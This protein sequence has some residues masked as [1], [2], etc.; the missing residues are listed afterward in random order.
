MARK[1][2]DPDPS[3]GPAVTPVHIG[4]DSILDRLLPNKDG[5]GYRL[6]SSGRRMTIIFEL[7]QTRTTFLDMFE[8]AIPM[9][10][11]VGI[12]A[13]IRPMDRSLWETRVRNGREFSGSAAR[14]ARH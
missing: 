1:D 5:E 9:F 2:A 4:G 12:D 7:D 3:L 11:Q 14:S 6:D 8:L 13:Q 10:Q